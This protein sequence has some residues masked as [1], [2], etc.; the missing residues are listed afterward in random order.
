MEPSTEEL[1]AFLSSP[2]LSC[3]PL[4]VS[5]RITPQA[6][7]LSQAFAGHTSANAPIELARLPCS[8][9]QPSVEVVVSTQPPTPL[10][11][12]MRRKADHAAATLDIQRHGDK[13][14][15]FTSPTIESPQPDSPLPQHPPSLPP[16][17][18]DTTPR[19]AIPT[20]DQTPAG[21]AGTPTARWMVTPCATEESVGSS[22]SFDQSSLPRSLTNTTSD[23]LSST[24][25]PGSERSWISGDVFMTPINP[26]LRRSLGSISEL[27]RSIQRF[28]GSP[29]SLK[30]PGTPD[31]HGVYLSLLQKQVAILEAR[32]NT[33]TRTNQQLRN[34]L[35]QLR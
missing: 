17:L 3:S 29:K 22:P 26:P 14:M 18:H 33:V 35:E 20:L 16:Q 23:S 9:V 13:F 34:E 5:P 1:G 6:Q 15:D 8:F 11:I 27:P 31:S 25:T 19:C 32:L 4:A 24:C 30:T 7:P 28:E 12:H 10:R 2:L 21:E